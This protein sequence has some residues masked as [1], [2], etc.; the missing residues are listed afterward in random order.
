MGIVDQNVLIF[1]VTHRVEWLSYL[2]FLFTDIGSF[3][4]ASII[5]GLLV[6]TLY[7]HKK[8]K[9]ILPYFIALVGSAGTMYLTKLIFYK[10]RPLDFALYLESGYSFPSGHATLAM[11]LY[12]FLIYIIYKQKNYRLKNL[13]IL[14]LILVILAIGFSRIYLGVHY[15]SDV[16]FGYLLG[17]IWIWIGLATV[18]SKNGHLQDNAHP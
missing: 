16:L 1:L 10:P 17:F 15:L 6:V 8:T 12:G 5:A 18:R 11:A 4:G 7:Y 13:V 9:F 14:G 2:M 3:L